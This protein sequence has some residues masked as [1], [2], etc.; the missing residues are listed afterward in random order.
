LV[1][2]TS[3]SMVTVAVEMHDVPLGAGG[4]SSASAR[5]DAG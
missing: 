1:A 3:S 2:A 5:N 4:A